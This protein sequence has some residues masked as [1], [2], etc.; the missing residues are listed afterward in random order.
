MKLGKKYTFKQN[1]NKLLEA[2]LQ[3]CKKTMI[4][5]QMI[6]KNSY[7]QQDQLQIIK[8]I[9]KQIKIEFKSTKNQA[10]IFKNLTIF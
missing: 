10:K 3:L 9:K 6:N 8:L 5:K 2:K 1:N 4:N 7:N